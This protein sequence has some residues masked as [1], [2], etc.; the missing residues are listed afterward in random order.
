VSGRSSTPAA[1][2]PKMQFPEKSRQVFFGTQI[3]PCSPEIIDDLLKD[4][5]QL[6]IMVD[7]ETEESTVAA[8]ELAS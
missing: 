7:Q 5:G 1:K 2:Y 8:N 4:L 3:E 6:P